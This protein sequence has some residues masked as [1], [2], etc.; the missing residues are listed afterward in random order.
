VESDVPG[1][2]VGKKEKKLGIRGSSTSELIFEN[3][4]VPKANLLG[5]MGGFRNCH[6]D[7]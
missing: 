4:R 7:S 2:S 3:C 5:N 1:F 6:E